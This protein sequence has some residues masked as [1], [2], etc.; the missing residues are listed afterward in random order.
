[1]RRCPLCSKTYDATWKI[2]LNDNSVL[3]DEQSIGD[4][5]IQHDKKPSM[6]ASRANRFMAKLLDSVILYSPVLMFLFPLSKYYQIVTAIYFMIWAFAIY[7]VQ[8]TLLSVNGQTI[9]KRY[10]KI[11]IIDY[12]TKGNPGFVK[13]VILRSVVMGIISSIF[14]KIFLFIDGL[15]IFKKNKRCLHDLLANTEVVSVGLN[16]DLRKNL[17]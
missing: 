17:K 1:M 5:S 11:R 6:L 4:E 14:L 10:F 2:C 13:C 12:K 9:G 16:P 7:I 3:R 15:F 8:C